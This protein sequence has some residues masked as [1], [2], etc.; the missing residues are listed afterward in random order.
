VR[1]AVIRRAPAKI[2]N[3]PLGKETG[4]RIQ[5]DKKDKRQLSYP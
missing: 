1:K 3:L 2:K 4:Y 5:E